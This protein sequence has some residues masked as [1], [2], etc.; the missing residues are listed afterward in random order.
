MIS[1]LLQLIQGLSW[2]CCGDPFEYPEGSFFWNENLKN[3]TIQLTNG[4]Y[5]DKTS[6]RISGY[7]SPGE[8]NTPENEEF[9]NSL[10]NGVIS[11]L[12][13][14]SVTILKNQ[15]GSEANASIEI[16]LEGTS[17]SQTDWYAEIDGVKYE[18]PDKKNPL[19]IENIYGG[20]KQIIVYIWNETL[21]QYCPFEKTIFIPTELEKRD[22]PVCKGECITLVSEGE[23]CVAWVD[24]KGRLLGNG[25]EYTI[26]PENDITITEIIENLNGIVVKRINHILQ[27][28]K[29]NYV[30]NTMIPEHCPPEEV[31]L[32]ISGTDISVTWADN[33]SEEK[34]RKVTSPG[35]YDVSILDNKNNCT[36]QETFIVG[37]D[38]FKDS[39]GDGLCDDKDCYPSDPALIIEKGSPCDDNNTC[40]INDKYN[41]NCQ[42][43]GEF[44]QYGLSVEIT[45]GMNICGQQTET[46]L[47]VEA[48]GGMEPYE[49][50]WNTGATSETINITQI[51]QGG[52]ETYS[53]TVTDYN[54]CSQEASVQLTRYDSD[55]SDG[56]GYCD[57]IDCAPYS[58]ELGGPGSPCDDGN[59][60]T[61]NDVHD[62]NCNCAGTPNPCEGVDSDG[63]GICDDV[64]CDDTK[65]E[66]GSVGSPCDDGDPNTINDRMN[67]DCICKGEFDQ[68]LCNL[69]ILKF[70]TYNTGSA[71]PRDWKV[72][73]NREIEY[74]ADFSYLNYNCI[75]T[76]WMW[77][78]GNGTCTTL[79]LYYILQSI[80]M[81]SIFK[82]KSI[83]GSN[84]A[85]IPNSSAPVK[86]D[87]F[88]KTNGLV[89]V[90][91]DKKQD[92]LM[93]TNTN[94]I[95][96]IFFEKDEISNPG[97]IDP[98]WYY[99]WE[100]FIPKKRINNLIFNPSLS[101]YASTDPVSREVEVSQI[102]SE[103]NDE[104]THD[105]LH[106]FYETI[107]HENHHIVLWEG[108][109]PT[110]YIASQDLDKDYYPDYWEDHD[111]D[112]QLY[113]FKSG[114]PTDNY[115][116]IDPSGNPSSG[117]L[118]EEDKCRQIEHN[119]N[120][121][122]FD[123]LDW[124]FDY[125][126]KFQGKQWK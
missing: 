57:E 14:Y 76:N 113:K 56:D 85:L 50:L 111:P 72:V 80:P 36:Y 122:D 15:I 38:I 20:S 96:E 125:L 16:L 105:G 44:P 24:E 116:Y 59:P 6:Y 102:A 54:G 92:C 48:T 41:E 29:S 100:Q 83:V 32:S 123:S 68:R 26:C 94:A 93:S 74:E 9:I 99:Y 53:V 86:N 43:E 104:T 52:G 115:S 120:E 73:M 95:I 69:R 75:G 121:T 107:E 108:W 90:T 71:L 63:D 45:G 1:W 27:T 60:N 30:L 23:Y 109:W 42:C 10:K 114:D 28:K 84:M 106:T 55:D 31:I 89:R 77:E 118:Y 22:D 103:Y 35:K 79:N 33:G 91:N 12:G 65:K 110:G 37:E 2:N 119:L 11:A 21:K 98:N 70:R 3:R 46:Q 78:I 17:G 13:E 62:A 49:I 8:P 4:R 25:I 81:G 39:D 7:S 64:D 88:G 97:G 124:S 18:N 61:I 87:E 126:N 5:S 40:T 51:S 112:A 58:A 67:V 101:G 117:Y 66:I 47:T 82:Q 34:E 19:K